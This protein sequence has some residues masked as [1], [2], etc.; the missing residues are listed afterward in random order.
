MRA[1]GLLHHLP[2][3]YSPHSHLL[4]SAGAH[5]WWYF[6]LLAPALSGPQTACVS[7]LAAQVLHR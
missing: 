6:P 5:V 7:P 2:C 3:T 1:G 4:F